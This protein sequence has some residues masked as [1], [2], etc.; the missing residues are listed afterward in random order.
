[1]FDILT[2]NL[3]LL[4]VMPFLVGSLW[5]IFIRV[6]RDREWS[7]AQAIWH[8]EM[9]T[10]AHHKNG[11]I[12]LTR[13]RGPGLV[14]LTLGAG[15]M[16]F[17]IPLSYQ[18]IPSLVVPLKLLISEDILTG[19]IA[20]FPLWVMLIGLVLLTFAAEWFMTEDTII[21]SHNG[22]V[23]IQSFWTRWTRSWSVKTFHALHHATDGEQ[24]AIYLKFR[25]SPE[26]RPLAIGIIPYSEAASTISLLKN[27]LNLPTTSEIKKNLDAGS[28]P[29]A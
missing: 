28:S 4:S 17:S 14:Y 27:V 26:K 21:S 25:D 19:I 15:I 20:G 8:F 10:I 22:L 7:S 13:S 24:S 16:I 11:D 23:K 2:L 3:I 5:L 6:Q 9:L 29:W 12:S 18:V 1:M